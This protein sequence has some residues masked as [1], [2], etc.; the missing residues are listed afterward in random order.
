LKNGNDSII[1]DICIGKRWGLTTAI[2]LLAIK[3]CKRIRACFKE[4]LI[5]K[6]VV[7]SKR[8]FWLNKSGDIS[9]RFVT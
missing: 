2:S 9:T 4:H 1:I 6:S 3:Q 5:L 8:W 7:K